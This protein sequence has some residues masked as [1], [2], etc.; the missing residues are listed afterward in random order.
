MRHGAPPGGRA[1]M[2]VSA[3]AGVVAMVGMWNLLRG[4]PAPGPQV[5][6][7]VAVGQFPAQDPGRPGPGADLRADLLRRL[8]EYPGLQ[9]L[10]PAPAGT[11]APGETEFLLDGSL[12]AGDPDWE[13]SVRLRD[14]DE[15]RVLWSDAFPLAQEGVEQAGHRVV[16]GLARTLK[17]HPRD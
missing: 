6:H 3:L 15:D 8:A 2:Y 9:V 13:L 14:L 5:R 10:E 17:V 1:L 11:Q 7:V 4:R 12:R 16:E